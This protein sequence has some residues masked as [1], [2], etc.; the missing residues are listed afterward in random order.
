M[1]GRFLGWNVVVEGGKMCPRRAEHDLGRGNCK[2]AK[3]K[4]DGLLEAVRRTN[5]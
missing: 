1:V 2:G 4:A 5:S 3:K